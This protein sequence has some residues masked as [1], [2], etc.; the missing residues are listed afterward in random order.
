M[1]MPLFLRFTLSVLAWAI[2]GQAC[3][4]YNL[5]TVP[6]ALTAGQPFLVV[7]DDDTCEDFFPNPPGLPP[8]FTVSGSQ[9]TLAVDRLEVPDCS[10]ASVTF[11]V[12][13]PGLATGNYSLLLI[14]RALQSPDNYGELQTVPL[15]VGQAVASK[16]RAIPSS[17][18]WS[19]A[20]LGS[21]MILAA[22][23]GSRRRLSFR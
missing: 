23:I 22:W 21:S 5:R 10:S 3:A 8:T 7:F 17:N 14:G 20:G 19:L 11:S 2:A 16:T 9:V 4:Q 1:G 18:A 13:V 12:P 6:A 15:T